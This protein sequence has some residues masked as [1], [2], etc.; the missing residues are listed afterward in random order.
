MGRRCR[1]ATPPAQASADRQPAS[2]PNRQTMACLSRT[3]RCQQRT[4]SAAAGPRACASASL[5][6]SSTLNA[7]SPVPPATSRCCIPAKGAN[8]DTSLRRSHG[9]P[10]A[11]VAPVMGHHQSTRGALSPALRALAC[12]ARKV[13][14]CQKI[15]GVAGCDHWRHAEHVPRSSPAST[16]HLGSAL[17]A[18]KP[19][20]ISLCA[21]RVPGVPEQ[22]ATHLS[23]Q[24]RCTP[25]D[26]RSFMRS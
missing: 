25:A 14:D 9:C 8:C 6:F 17:T 4:G 10:V 26:M 2:Q 23:F 15:P 21:H 3:A 16:G 12:R 18:S 13:T 20:P 24:S 7:M 1:S 19:R 11:T 5:I 22:A